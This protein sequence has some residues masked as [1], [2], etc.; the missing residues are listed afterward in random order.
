MPLFTNRT[1]RRTFLKNMA[2][3][4]GSI[5]SIGM[6][7]AF[8]A[9]AKPDKLRLALMSDLHVPRNTGN[10]YR[11]FYPY[12]NFKN[13]AIEVARSGLDGAV[14][15]G[16]LAR[17]TGESGDYLNLKQL[18]QPVFD[19]MPVAMTFGN[20]DNRQHFFEV[21]TTSYGERQNIQ[22][23]YVLV[24]DHPDVQ[25][26]LL[27]SLLSTNIT[28]GLLGKQQRRWL[29]K[30]L[31]RQKT[32]PVMLFFHHTL[33]DGDNDLLDVDKLFEIITPH[34][35]VKAVFYGHSHVYRFSTRNDIH[36]I[37]LPALGYNF[38]PKQPVGWI[39]ASL[40]GAGGQFTLH[41]IG[42]NTE[43]D[44]ETNNLIWRR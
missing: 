2:G 20:H 21:F 40:D 3:A 28:P 32:K 16:D 44:G 26:I 39:E 6:F 30:H 19:K 8:P 1:D 27:D 33:S 10:N 7:A 15:T 13:A 4:A 17:L 23:K 29:D 11:G 38:T 18:S 24:I 41:A 43:H 36:L 9:K 22:N 34:P 37:N 35:Q 5:A 42:G 25:L 12:N 14:I 31:N